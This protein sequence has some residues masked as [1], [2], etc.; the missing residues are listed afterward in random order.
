MEDSPPKLCSLASGGAP[1]P[2]HSFDFDLPSD[3]VVETPSRPSPKDCADPTSTFFWTDICASD[4]EDTN[5]RL[6]DLLSN[7]EKNTYYNG[8]HIWDAIYTENCDWANQC[9]EETVLYRLLSGLHSSTSVAISKNYHPP[10]GEKK[11][12]VSA[13]KSSS[14]SYAIHITSFATCYAWS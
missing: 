10:S 3:P 12:N 13:A 9:Y 11:C 5:L 8:S 7:P 6:I 2:S 4:E 1:S 14:V